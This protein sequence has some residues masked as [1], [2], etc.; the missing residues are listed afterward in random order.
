MCTRGDLRCGTLLLSARDL[1]VAYVSEGAL[2]IMSKRNET[3]LKAAVAAIALAIPLIPV[4]QANAATG[5]AIQGGVSLFGRD[6]TLWR[7][8]DG[9]HGQISGGA[10]TY[11]DLVQVRSYQDI[12]GCGKFTCPMG[13]VTVASATIPA[14]KTSVNTNAV[15]VSGTSTAVIV[16]IKANNRPDVACS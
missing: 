1:R 9:Y 7:C 16:C 15:F 2:I 5:C 3:V 14:G 8:S 11:Q 13:W 10:A 6:G 4:T 12:G